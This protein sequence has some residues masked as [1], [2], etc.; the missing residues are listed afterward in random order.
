MYFPC[1]DEVFLLCVLNFDVVSVQQMNRSFDCLNLAY[2]CC[3]VLQ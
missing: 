2:L 3:C 1:P